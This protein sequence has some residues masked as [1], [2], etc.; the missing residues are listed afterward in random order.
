MTSQFLLEIGIE[1]MP[2]NQI[3]WLVMVL[4]NN[5]KD[6]FKKIGLTFGLVSTFSSPRRL[7]V[8]IKSLPKIHKNAMISKRT[9]ELL[10]SIISNSIKKISL[11][12]SMF[13]EENR[14]PFIRPINWLMAIFGNEIISVKIFGIQ[15]SNITYGHRFHYP[16]SIV[17]PDP[18]QYEILLDKQGLVMA[19]A[20]KRKHHIQNQII[21]LTKNNQAIIP[22][23]LLLEVTNLVEWPVALEGVFNKRFL[24]IPHEILI[25]SLKNHQRCFPIV[26]ESGRLLPRF[27]MISNIVSKIPARII[28]GNEK[29]INARFTDAEYFYHNDLK[30]KFIDNLYKLRSVS[31]QEKL[32]S[33]Y[34]KTIRLQEIITFIAT[35]IGINC[36]YAQRA[37]MLSKCDLITSMVR[38]F[39][40]L[41]GIMGYY[42]TVKYESN[43]VALAIKEQYLPRFSKDV[44]PTTMLGCC[45][46]LA[47]RID[48]LVGFFIINKIPTGNKDPFGLRR[49]AAGI[50]KIILEKKLDLDLKSV[51]ER[52]YL[53]YSNVIKNN[54]D[55]T[56]AK[57]FDFIYERLNSWYLE[58]DRDINIFRA[59]LMR[60]STNLQDFD[61]RFEAIERF[62]QLPEICD[63][64]N[65]YKRIK[66]ILDHAKYS[67]ENKFNLKLFIEPAEDNLAKL[68][69][70][71]EQII[72][73][74]Y[75]NKNYFELLQELAKL[76]PA[77]DDF[78]N[79]VMIMTNDEKLRHNRLALL[80]IL[81]NLFTSIMDPSYLISS[82]KLSSKI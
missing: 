78:F 31:F 41:Q 20:K 58:Q 10:P 60:S 22:E 6:G 47:D 18:E 12:K 81:E 77:I 57:I 56:I 69:I 46:A 8:S 7:A 64:I 3:D 14:G 74:L 29:I 15:A 9:I 17:I 21:A 4:A 26:D 71:E 53:A 76:K 38:E 33:L 39:P 36:A 82:N 43:D 72:I 24:K 55:E 75:Q 63:L 37:A 2:P 50:L 13:W 34:D 49:A 30:L 28:A 68:I 51:L 79:R 40:E 5:L 19:D 27:V 70:K 73:R 61:K 42:Y 66:N 62:A 44:I 45:L 23:D 25:T 54:Q 48:N 80:K 1:E 59:V 11:K 65:N 67:S 52:S 16:K 35:K 32:G